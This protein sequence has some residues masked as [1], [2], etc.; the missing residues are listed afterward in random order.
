M[1]VIAREKEIVID[2]SLLVK[3]ISDV[4]IY[5][6][7]RFQLLQRDVVVMMEMKNRRRTAAFP[8]TCTVLVP[9]LVPLYL[10]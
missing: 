8:W 6:T 1:K 7:R 5:Q 3:V 10:Y 4:P 9:V 2:L